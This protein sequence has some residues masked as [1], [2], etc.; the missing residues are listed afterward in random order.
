GEAVRAGQ[1]LMSIYS[2]DLLTTQREFVDLLRRRDNARSQT[3]EMVADN[4]D[5]LI[6]SA[7]RR[8]QQWNITPEQLIEL[9]RTRQASEHLTLLSPFTGVV[10]DLSVDQGRRV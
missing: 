9:E 2:P 1:P 10:Q 3:S 8:L 4:I 5:R 6:D 7:R